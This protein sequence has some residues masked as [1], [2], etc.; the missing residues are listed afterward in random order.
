[1]YVTFGGERI[2][3]STKEK[4]HPRLWD[5]KNCKVIQNDKRL[6]RIRLKYGIISTRVSK[7]SLT[8]KKYVE[9][10]D[11]YFMKSQLEGLPQEVKS[12]KR[13]LLEEVFSNRREERT[14][15]VR[16]ISMY[17]SELY[18][19]VRKKHNGRSYKESSITCFK[20]LLQAYDRFESEHGVKLNFDQFFF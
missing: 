6:D 7:V 2:K 17:I 16:Y 11:T 10:V 12:C 15:I 9:A 4:I 14:F 1:M 5:F 3:M 19:K 20:N 18:S 13:Y 8:L